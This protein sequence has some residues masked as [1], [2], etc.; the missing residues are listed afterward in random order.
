MRQPH[1]A[2]VIRSIPTYRIEHKLAV[3]RQPVMQRLPADDV[4]RDLL[5]ILGREG[6]KR[7]GVPPLRQPVTLQGHRHPGQ[8]C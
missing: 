2:A 4:V 6:G 1:H 5:H 3:F 8:I 7:F